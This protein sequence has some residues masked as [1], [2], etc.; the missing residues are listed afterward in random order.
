MLTGYSIAVD[1]AIVK[2][3]FVFMTTLRQYSSYR[4][5]GARNEAP[6]R[7]THDKWCTG[8][9]RK[10][11][12]KVL[13]PITTAINSAG[14]LAIDGVDL[15]ELAR[16]YGTPLYIYDEATIRHCCRA[17]RTAF[18]QHYPDS[19]VVYAGKTYLSPAILKI[20]REEAVWLDLCSGGELS[21]ALRCDFP[22][23]RV[24]YHG[25]NKTVEELR[26]AIAAGV[27]R[28][29]VDN[30]LELD[31]IIAL[32]TELDRRVPIILRLNPGVGAH[33]HEYRLTG[34]VDS[35][36]GFPT[37]DDQAEQAVV[38]ALQAEATE[39]LGYHCHIGAH[40]F[41]L[42]PYREAVVSLFRFAAT[43]HDRHGF[44]PAEISP[45][46]GMAISYTPEDQDRQ[47]SPDEIATVIGSALRDCAAE[48]GLPAPRT[49]IEPGR[50]L[51]GQAGVALYTVGSV[52]EIP[53]VRRY[54]AVDG[55][56]SDNIRPAL[57]EAEY[58]A[59]IANRPSPQF[60]VAPG[61]PAAGALSSRVVGK[62][63]ESG[64]L[65]IREIALPAV[66]PG[67]LLALP[68][69]GA[70][71]LAMSSNY[72]LA[73]RPAVIFIHQGEVRLTRRRETLD[74]LLI[75]EVFP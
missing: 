68:A 63:C 6:P 8:K 40:I 48:V 26:L 15:T 44:I 24:V 60:H 33:T 3:V 2:V 66:V 62:Y 39:L 35:K 32:G 23:E 11:Q 52:K 45:G 22:A 36:F 27:G 53:G 65:L 74:D 41:E 64:D 43:M 16:D 70:Y 69:S 51:V 71:N 1:I 67:D 20:L 50:A 58:T 17:F 9:K 57:Y 54:V 10:D 49:W 31:R 21:L 7:K 55:G 56:M 59:A 34:V 42:E 28:I 75:A 30:A 73:Y 72:N 29:V 4:Y 46:G 13:W 12:Q 47:P 14:H 37:I 19:A 18:D 61:S 25:N 38:R 5:N